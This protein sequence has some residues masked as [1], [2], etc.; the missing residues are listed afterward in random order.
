MWG[1]NENNFDVM[2]SIVEDLQKDK[3][4]PWLLMP[5]R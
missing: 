1:G 2:I 5:L 4:S 3:E